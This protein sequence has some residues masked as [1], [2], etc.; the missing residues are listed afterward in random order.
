M[1]P[2]LLHIDKQYCDI[3]CFNRK[4]QSKQ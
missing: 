2:T 4:R 1:R 3:Y